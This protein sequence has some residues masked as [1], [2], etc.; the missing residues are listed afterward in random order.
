MIPSIA[1]STTS[2][3]ISTECPQNPRNR[4]GT[5]AVKERLGG[6]PP[7]R[8]VR[9]RLVFPDKTMAS[10]DAPCIDH[11]RRPRNSHKVIDSSPAMEQKIFLLQQHAVVVTAVSKLHAASPYSINKAV[12]KEFKIPAHLLRITSHDPE[13][14]LITFNLPAHK[15][16]L[17][18]RGS[19][20]VDGVVFLM[21]PWRE[22]THALHQTWMLH[23]RVILE[24][25]LM[26]LWTLEGA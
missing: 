14:F 26:Q 18:R 21:E 5:G 9:E 2:Q 11:G 3:A 23:V 19:L 24:K 13:D 17:V 16:L 15:D 7:T 20:T 1:L 8:S 4:R 6:R 10:A 12:E 25:L 22:D